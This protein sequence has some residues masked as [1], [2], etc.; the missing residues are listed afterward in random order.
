MQ[1]LIFWKLLKCSETSHWY[2]L[3]LPVCLVFLKH[4]FEQ[5]TY[6]L[7]FA[8]YEFAVNDK[9]MKVASVNPTTSEIRQFSKSVLDKIEIAR[10]N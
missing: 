2:S 9:N 6:G 3:M 4:H 5:N 7:I 10:S 8:D 1:I